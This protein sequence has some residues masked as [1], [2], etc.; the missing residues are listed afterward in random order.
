MK[1]GSVKESA[2]NEPRVAMTPDSA[3]QLQKLG[4][5]CLIEAG[6]GKAAGFSDDAY[7]AVGVTVVK[8]AAAL[9][10]YGLRGLSL[11]YLPFSD[12]NVVAL[13]I[14]AV[15]MPMG[16]RTLRLARHG[17]IVMPIGQGRCPAT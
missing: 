14:F 2:C 10:F 11:L 15:R 9:W 7:R 13:S 16:S 4:Y 8:G 6:A 12:F 1:F 3:I 5:E 17:R